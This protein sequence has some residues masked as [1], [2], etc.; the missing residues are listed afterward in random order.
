[1][2]SIS[3]QICTA[4]AS[5]MICGYS[6][7]ATA[8]NRENEHRD[9][10]WHENHREYTNNDRGNH[11]YNDHRDNRN[12]RDRH[13]DWNKSD[14]GDRHN[15][16]ERHEREQGH[17]GRTVF[18]VPPGYLPHPGECRV[19]YP[20]RPAFRQPHDFYRYHHFR[21]EPRDAYVVRCE[22]DNHDRVKVHLCL[23]GIEVA[24]Q[25]YDSHSGAFLFEN[26]W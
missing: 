3:S 9:F 13:D 1:M 5:I 23:N 14:N 7:S 24:V 11:D 16:L 26:R 12:D 18:I 20:D 22:P 25:W 21:E 4:A 8:D 19:W 2:K 6:I 15:D 17:N 10:R